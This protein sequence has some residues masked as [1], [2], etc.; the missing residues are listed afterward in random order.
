[1]L[2]DSQLEQIRALWQSRNKTDPLD[3]KQLHELLKI[4]F[5][6]SL[7]REEERPVEV[8]FSLLDR[9]KLQGGEGLSTTTRFLPLSPE[10]DFSTDVLVKLSGAL[11]T[12]NSSLIIVRNGPKYSVA[13]IA[14]FGWR[15]S[16]LDPETASCPPPWSLTVMAR[17]PGHLAI[18]HQGSVFARYVDGTILPVEFNPLATSQLTTLIGKTI[19]SH[20]GFLRHRQSYEG[21]YSACIDRLLALAE[22][23]GHGGTILWVPTALV[24]ALP[25]WVDIRRRFDSAPDITNEL[26]GIGETDA[27]VHEVLKRAQTPG[28]GEWRAIDAMGIGYRGISHRRR[29]NEHLALLAQLTR[30]DGA[31]VIDDYLRPLGFSAVIRTTQEWAGPVEGMSRLAPGLVDLTKFGTRHRSA[32]TFA[33]NCAGSIAFVISQDGAVRGMTRLDS[34][35]LFWPDCLDRSF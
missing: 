27:N 25:D 30:V 22:A 35:V 34:K 31:L 12:H 9:E 28:A 7:R 21:A 10:P 16:Y 14:F 17:Q 24:P 15:S 33:A 13:G 5:F 2:T 23:R 1:M 29:V 32:V 4:A 20:P 8:R 26:A 18:A 3:L 6:A 11:D 19:E